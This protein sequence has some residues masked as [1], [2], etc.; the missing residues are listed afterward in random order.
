VALRHRDVLVKRNLEIIRKNL[1]LL[2]SFFERRADLFDWVRPDASPIGFVRFKPARDVQEFCDDVVRKSGVM[3]LPGGVYDEAR[4]IRFGYGRKNMPEAL[5]QFD[6]Y[7][8][9]SL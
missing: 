9:A 8:R 3:L 4:H 1:A 5:E 2:D 6:G 7:L